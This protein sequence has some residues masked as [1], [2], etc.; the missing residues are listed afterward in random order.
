MLNEIGVRV[1]KPMLMHVNNQ[2]AI[3]KIQGEDSS[4]G[5][6]HIAVSLKFIKDYNKKRLSRF[7]IFKSHFM[8]ADLLTNTFAVPRLTELRML[9]LLVSRHLGKEC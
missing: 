9:I 3:K 7:C 4:R 5:E 2:A 8:R 1:A 6:N